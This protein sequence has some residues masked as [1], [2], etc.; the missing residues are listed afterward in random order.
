MLIKTN[1]KYLQ[2]KENVI[3]LVLYIEIGAPSEDFQARDNFTTGNTFGRMLYCPKW[4]I[5]YIR[6]FKGYFVC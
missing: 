3:R 5:L 4:I 2:N 6:G 1:N